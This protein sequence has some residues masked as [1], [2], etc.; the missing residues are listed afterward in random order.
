MSQLTGSADAAQA[1]LLLAQALHQMQAKHWDEAMRLLE[2]AIAAAPPELRDSAVEILAS[3]YVSRNQHVRLRNLMRSADPGSP[4]MIKG[5]L[6]LARNHALGVD[7]ELPAHCRADVLEPAVHAHIL[8]GAYQ[9]AELPVVVA[10]VAQLGWAELA[11][12]IAMLCTSGHVAIEQG[13]LERV[14]ATLIA[15]GRR[16]K[17]LELLDALRALPESAE[18]PIR[19]WARLLGSK[20]A[21][22]VAEDTAQ[23]KVARFLQSMQDRR[24]NL[25]ESAPC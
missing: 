5:A 6:L 23:D 4:Q 9:L 2:S 19:R 24:S 20:H 22:A 16:N 12:R 15:A 17:A 11:E 10:L 7:G 25:K 1:Q 13:V 21:G 3:I 8:A 14:F 18:R